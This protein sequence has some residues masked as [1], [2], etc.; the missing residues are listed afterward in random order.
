[1]ARRGRRARWPGCITGVV[2]VRLRVRDL[3]AGIITM[4]AL[5]SI[6]L[7]IAGSNLPVERGTDTIFTAAP[8]MALF[9]AT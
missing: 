7:Q 6:N 3:L 5:F 9:W 8:A 4:T 2:H 1:M